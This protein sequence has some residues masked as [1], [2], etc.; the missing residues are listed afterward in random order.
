L[1]IILPNSVRFLH[2]QSGEPKTHC[3]VFVRSS[4]IVHPRKYGITGLVSC[5]LSF[6]HFKSTYMYLWYMYIYSLIFLC[7]VEDTACYVY[8]A[9]PYIYI[10]FVTNFIWTITLGILDQFQQ[11]KWLPKA[12]K[13][14]FQKIPKESQGNQYSPSYQQIS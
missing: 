2:F 1:T 4:Y 5:A 10:F 11:S 14:T 7:L 13:K 6:R 12:F 3:W 9:S 8:C